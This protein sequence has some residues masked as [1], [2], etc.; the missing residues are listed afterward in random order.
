MRIKAGRSNN[1]LLPEARANLQFQTRRIQAHITALSDWTDALQACTERSLVRL[2]P[3]LLRSENCCFA[4]FTRPRCA[5]KRD[6]TAENCGRN[7][8]ELC[9]EALLSVLSNFCLRIRVNNAAPPFLIA[10]RGSA[11]SRAS[12]TGRCRPASFIQRSLDLRMLGFTQ[13]RGGPRRAYVVVQIFCTAYSIRYTDI[14]HFN[15]G[16]LLSK[17]L[18]FINSKNLRTIRKLVAY[19]NFQDYSTLMIYNP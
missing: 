6:F 1:F 2:T 13:H 15:P 14:P 8:C 12:A 5:D 16:N 7:M 11:V 4:S 3:A 19:G 10:A 18:I 17:L 9:S